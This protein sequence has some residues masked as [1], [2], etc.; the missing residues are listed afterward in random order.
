MLQ[1]SL[2]K[3]MKFAQ[4]KAGIENRAAED[5]WISENSGQFVAGK[6]K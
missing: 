5:A 3:R 4:Q 2:N 1:G 6:S